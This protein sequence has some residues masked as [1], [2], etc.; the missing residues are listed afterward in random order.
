MNDFGLAHIGTAV[1][2]R[3]AWIK[4]VPYRTWERPRGTVAVNDD[5]RTRFYQ[6]NRRDRAA[7]RVWMLDVFGGMNGNRV[8]GRWPEYRVDR[9]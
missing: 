4:G 7:F 3:P 1:D 2:G 9:V 5:G 8:S 6:V